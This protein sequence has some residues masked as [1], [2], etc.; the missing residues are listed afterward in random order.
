MHCLKHHH[1]QSRDEFQAELA[2]LN[3][4]WD[5]EAKESERTGR[6]VWCCHLSSLGLEGFGCIP[7]HPAQRD[8][9]AAGELRGAGCGLW[10]VGYGLGVV[11][12]LQ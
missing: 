6:W 3:P 7:H 2:G 11:V 9:D 8:L 12:R 1:A 4:I 5:G 10:A